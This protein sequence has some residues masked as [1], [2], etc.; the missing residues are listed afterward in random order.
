[1]KTILFLIQKEFIQV[2]RNKMMLPIIFVVP[3]IQLIVLVHAATFELKKVDLLIIDKDISTYSNRLRNKIEGI[4]FFEV[5]NN[6]L[7]TKAGQK[8]ILQNKAD[9]FIEIPSGMEKNIINGEKTSIQFNINAIDGVAA[10]LTNAYLNSVLLDF[11]KEIVTSSG[12]ANALLQPREIKISSSFWYNPE[13]NYKTYM[14]PG[15]LVLL[16]TILGMFLSSMN[17]VREKEIGTIEQINVTPIK[18]YQFII[19]K[20]VPFVIIAL[21]ELSIG[22]LIG[23]LFFRIPTVGSIFL[24]FGIAIV[25]LMVVLGIGLLISTITNTQQ[26]AMFI[27]FFFMLIFVLMSGLFT[28]I[29]SMPDWAIKLNYINPIAYY[30]KCMRMILLKGSGL[31][32]VYKEVT[33]L[34]VYSALVLPLAIWKYRK[35]V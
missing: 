35:R 27:A 13:L 18:K 8:L 6:T 10:E 15:I 33:S 21:V 1:M 3:M 22:L 24:I 5:T 23:K 17:L 29:E 32:D 14:V 26:Q 28:S 31:T 30:I 9:V 16:V 25:Y 2:F 12:Q 7:S 20:L 19:G 4:P 34:I 11:N